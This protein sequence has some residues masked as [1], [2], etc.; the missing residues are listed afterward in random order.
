MKSLPFIA[1]QRSIP[2]EWI[3]FNGHMNTRYYADVLYDAHLLFTD[4][5]DLGERYRDETHCSKATVESHTLYER[6]LRE[7]DQIEI[8]SWVIGVDNKRLHT[9]QELYCT[10]AE[11]VSYRAAAGEFMDVHMDL[12]TRRSSDF[13]R[14]VF[15]QLRALLNDYQSLTAPAGSGRRI[16][17]PTAKENRT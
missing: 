13:P 7:G 6:E 12:N 4:F 1:L 16:A 5:L 14:P 3:D 9:F 11:G 8:R 10:T 15:E 17:I 2:I